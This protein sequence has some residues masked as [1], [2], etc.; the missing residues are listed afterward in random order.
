MPRKPTGRPPGR[1]PGSGQL[2]DA[3]RIT[4]WLAGEVYDKLHTYAEGRHFYRGEPELAACVRELLAHALAC[5]YKHLTQNI[6]MLS[7]DG[8][9]QIETITAVPENNYYEQI[10]TVPLVTENIYTQIETVPTTAENSSRQIETVPASVHPMEKPGD[11]KGQTTHAPETRGE[12]TRQTD[13]PP[14]DS[15]WFYL[16]KLCPAQHDYHGSGQS[17]L[18]RHNG[19]CRECA[20]LAKRAARETKRQATA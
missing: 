8:N 15:T 7:R 5:P 1:P 10:Q 4:V 12:E 2:A 20:R 18:R 17:L 16:G 19:H 13:I 3:R 6:P 11:A 14:Y 9:R